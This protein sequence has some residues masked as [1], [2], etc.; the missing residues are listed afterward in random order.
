[1]GKVV[2]VSCNGSG[3]HINDIDLDLALEE[4]VVYRGPA[5]NVQNLPE[6]GVT[7][8]CRSCSEGRIVITR[9][10]LQEMLNDDHA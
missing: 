6:R 10:M 1:M 2:Q 8:R 9:S 5:P 3:E 4:T 7:L